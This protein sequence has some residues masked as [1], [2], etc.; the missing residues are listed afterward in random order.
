MAEPERLSAA[1]AALS[2]PAGPSPEDF[3]VEWWAWT[4]Q[5]RLLRLPPGW[6]S[7]LVELIDHGLTREDLTASVRV[8]M[9]SDSVTTANKYRYAIGVARRRAKIRLE[10]AARGGPVGA[11]ADLSSLGPYIRTRSGHVHLPGCRTLERANPYNARA[12]ASLVPFR[13]CSVC[14]SPKGSLG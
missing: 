11:P 8:A 9:E 10:A 7:P 13:A 5:G 6:R 14:L 12:A 4:D 1:L 3:R 2:L